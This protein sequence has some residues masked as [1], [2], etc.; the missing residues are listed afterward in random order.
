MGFRGGKNLRETCN[1]P[2]VLT[3]IKMIFNNSQ[4]LPGRCVINAISILTC[5]LS[6]PS[7]ELSNKLYSTC[8]FIAKAICKN[9]SGKY[10]VDPHMVDM[11]SD[12][13]NGLLR[14]NLFQ[15]NQ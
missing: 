1:T 10:T 4:N 6:C 13:S 12:L 2:Q 9:A 7:I 14:Y 8:M 11:A 5:F 3:I 15:F